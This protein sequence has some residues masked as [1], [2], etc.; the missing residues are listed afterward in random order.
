AVREIAPARVR[1]P[2]AEAAV[3]EPDEP[4]AVEAGAR[5]RAAP[6]VRDTEEM[7]GVRGDVVAERVRRV[8]SAVLHRVASRLGPVD[9]TRHMRSV[10]SRGAG[11]PALQCEHQGKGNGE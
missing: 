7:A 8:T 2:D 3:D 5:R 9:E 11:G 1:Q 10:F 6:A 4:R